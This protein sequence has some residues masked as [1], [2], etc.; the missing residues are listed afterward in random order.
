[1]MTPLLETMARGALVARIERL[2]AS[3]KQQARLVQLLASGFFH[4]VQDRHDAT[5][6][7]DDAYD[8]VA[9]RNARRLIATQAKTAGND[10]TS[11]QRAET[12]RDRRSAR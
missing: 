8:V 1:M 7:T 6:H 3:V 2:E 10:I 11:V 4:H 12:K 5:M 9:I